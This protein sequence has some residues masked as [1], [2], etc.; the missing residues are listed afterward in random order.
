[1]ERA[2]N[3]WN[4]GGHRVLRWSGANPEEVTIVLNDDGAYVETEKELPIAAS[5]IEDG[6]YSMPLEEAIDEHEKLVEV[7]EK[8]EPEAIAEEAK[9]QGGELQEMLDAQ[10]AKHAKE[11]ARASFLVPRPRGLRH[12]A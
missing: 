12:H 9:E 11:N 6:V 4:H 7:L 8:D 1:M 3:Q 2:L 5:K 10:S